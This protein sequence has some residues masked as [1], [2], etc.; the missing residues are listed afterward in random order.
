MPLPVLRSVDSR[1]K[2]REDHNQPFLSSGKIQNQLKLINNT[3]RIIVS[4]VMIRT[5]KGAGESERMMAVTTKSKQSLRKMNP[6][7]LTQETITSA[8]IDCQEVLDD[9]RG[10]ARIRTKSRAEGE[11]YHWI[12]SSDP[13]QVKLIL[14]PLGKKWS[15]SSRC[16]RLLI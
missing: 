2:S 14:C 1:R 12:G 10:A 13:S 6:E 5:E 16:I 15:A 4:I 9:A 8:Q 3:R 7:E 11:V